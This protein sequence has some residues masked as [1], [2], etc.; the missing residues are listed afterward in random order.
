MKIIIFIFC[1]TVLSL[2]IKAQH[3]L[4]FNRTLILVS[5]TSYTVPINTTWKVENAFFSNYG[6]ALF[7]NSSYAPTLI[8]APPGGNSTTV[9]YM[10]Q[11]QGNSYA[12]VNG[13]GLPCWLP[14]G[15]TIQATGATSM[16]TVIEFI[17]Q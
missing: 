5:G 1:A 14:E 2:G 11:A 16:L 12:P 3:T 7:Y 4:A 10:G 15:T 13:Y 8:I 9:Y 6:A 17:I